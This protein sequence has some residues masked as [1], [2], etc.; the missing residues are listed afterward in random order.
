LNQYYI[1]LHLGKDRAQTT[2]WEVLLWLER[3]LAVKQPLQ[4]T[5]KSM[6]A[7]FMQK[8][9]PRAVKTVILAVLPLVMRVAN[10]LAYTAQ[11]VGALA[12]V[13]KKGNNERTEIGSLIARSGEMNSPAPAAL[14]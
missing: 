4:R 14:S 9:A 8:S 13:P 10:A 3:K 1:S 5:R 7:I 12:G 11:S 2:L 6:A